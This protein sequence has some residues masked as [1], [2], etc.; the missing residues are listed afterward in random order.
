MSEVEGTNVV[1]NSH[2][3]KVVPSH[4]R[5]SKFPKLDSGKGFSKDIRNLLL[6]GNMFDGNGFV[7]DVGTK[8]MEANG[9]VLR[10][11]TSSMVC[12]DFNATL[13]IFEGFA[14]NRWSKRAQVEPT[15]F[16]FIDE[17]DNRHDLTKSRRQSDVFGFSG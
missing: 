5:N 16:Q 1:A 11:W 8:V 9:K 4:E 13:I 17:I 10:S 6:G 12:C 14:D 3:G 2:R 7:H 15:A